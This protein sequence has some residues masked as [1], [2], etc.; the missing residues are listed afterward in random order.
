MKAISPVIATILLVMIAVAASVFLWVWLSGYVTSTSSEVETGTESVK[1][2]VKIDGV[3]YYLATPKVTIY[4]TNIGD[5]KT[6]I[7]SAYVLDASGNVVASNTTVN[8]ELDPGTTGSV[9]V[10]LG[11]RLSSGTYVAKVVTDEGVEATYTFT[12]S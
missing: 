12:A 6:K 2:A 4:V 7:T 10:T 3:K 8:L 1:V 9:N 11:S 5:V